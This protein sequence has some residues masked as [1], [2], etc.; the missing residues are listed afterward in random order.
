MDT[1]ANI[2]KNDRTIG[3]GN[4]RTELTVEVVVRNGHKRRERERGASD[5]A[6]WK[7]PRVSLVG[8][9]FGF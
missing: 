3:S 6:L 1:P 8:P 7:V 2:M 5:S 9:G 4:P